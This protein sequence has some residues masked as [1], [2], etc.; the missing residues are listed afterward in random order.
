[1]NA[2][3]QSLGHGGF[4]DP[5]FSYQ[6]GV[7]LFSTAENLHHTFNFLIPPDQ[8]IKRSFGGPDG[9]VYRKLFQGICFAFFLLPAR[10][11]LWIAQWFPLQIIRQVMGDIFYDLHST[12]SLAAQEIDGLGIRFGKD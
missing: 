7:V 12:Y 4:A 8:R 6:Q 3:G 1:M 2:Q 5:G 11:R 9:K 10:R